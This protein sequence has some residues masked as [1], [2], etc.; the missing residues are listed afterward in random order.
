MTD[1]HRLSIKDLSADLD[2]RSTLLFHTP[3]GARNH[4]ATLCTLRGHMQE[5]TLDGKRITPTAD[6]LRHAERPCGYEL[7]GT[8]Y[9]Y[10]QEVA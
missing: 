6:D 2:D 3:E 9:L 5:F 10:V 1:H 7:G 8:R 4:A